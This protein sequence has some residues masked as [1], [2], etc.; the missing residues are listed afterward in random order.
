MILTIPSNFI[1]MDEYCYSYSGFIQGTLTGSNI[2]CK[3]Y[4]SNQ[5]IISGYA[6]LATSASLSIKLYLAIDNIGIGN[7]SD[8]VNII[9][10]SSANNVIINANTAS[11]SYTIAQAGSP[12]L[13]LSG[14]MNMPYTSGNAFPLYI[15]FQLRSNTLV[16]GDYL[17]VNFG[18]WVIDLATSGAQIF[19]YRLSGTIYWVPSQ[20]IKMSGNTYK[21]PVYNNYSMNSG[22]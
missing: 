17:L 6:T 19:K 9:A 15:K 4:S 13:G 2:V 18:N 1:I 3:G 12:S 22:N 14:T 21:I 10:Y 16:N 11:Y 20:A 8:Y 5:I 7:Y